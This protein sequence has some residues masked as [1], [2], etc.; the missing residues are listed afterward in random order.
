[1]WV[2]GLKHNLVARQRVHLQSHPMWVRGLKHQDMFLA[3][4]WQQSHPMWVRGLKHLLWSELINILQSHPMWV[5]GLKHRQMCHPSRV[6]VAP[7]VG[8][9][10]ETKQANQTGHNKDGRTLCGCVD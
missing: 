10:I 4:S 2:R 9:W 1:M 5:R 6:S 7:Y 3:A 8:A